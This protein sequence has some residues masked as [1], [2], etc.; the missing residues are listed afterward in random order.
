MK[1]IFSTLAYVLLLFST[2]GC[3]YEVVEGP[4]DSMGYVE[5]TAVMEAAPD[6]KTAMSELTQGMYYPLWSPE[7]EIAVFADD[8]KTP[9]KFVLSSGE[10]SVKA[11]F[12][13]NCTGEC[14][15]A[16]Y[17]Y[18]EGVALND[19][20]L[21][22][23]LPQTQKYVE[24]SFGQGAY[25]MIATGGSDGV[26]NFMNL[27][28][29]LKI[30]LSGTASVRA[31][32]V[33][34]NDK[35]TY[36]SGP[37][38]VSLNAIET[39][40]NFL[41]MSEGAS[42]SVTLD[43][44]GLEISNE[45]PADV[46][47]VIP[48]QTYKGGLTIEVDTF[49]ETISRVIEIDLTFA[50]SQL[51]SIPNFVL[52]SDMEESFPEV[53]T[54]QKAT[55]GNGIDIVLMGDAYTERQIKDGTYREEMEF[56]YENLFTEEPYA[57]FRDCFNVYYVNVISENEGYGNWE[58][59]LQGRFG[60]G[61]YVE[62]NHEAVVE[63]AEKAIPDGVLM[64]TLIVVAMNSDAYAGTCH[65]FY[66]NPYIVKDYGTGLSIAYF[67]RG[68]DPETFK[69]LLHHEACGHGFA[70]LDDEYDYPGVISYEE[71]SERLNNRNNWGWWK[72][73]DFTDD[74]S[75][76]VWA[77][78][79]ED[80]RYVNEKLGVFEGA[81]TYAEGAWRP[82]E[83]SIMRYNFGGFNAPSR[84]AI[85]YRIHK[86]AYGKN[87][88]YDYEEFVS[89]DA[90]NRT[91]AAVAAR[92]QQLNCVERTFEPTHPPVVGKFWRDVE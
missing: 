78:F 38:S 51:R 63:Y 7:D 5:L 86:L 26:L 9:S 14:Y 71:I 57:S 16:L 2:V 39:E 55:K 66:P 83:N 21:S 18:N 52:D 42:S 15:V 29:V 45:S 73:V 88:E 72:N 40:D 43:C 58:T 62:G 77:H 28:S 89:Y 19:G 82:T 4:V 8:D 68:G 11:E 75:E 47:I 37:A 85:Y 50:R 12:S 27:C 70:K 69:Q 41:A 64:E 23:T 1:K 10:G 61:T 25:P 84:E 56:I 32:T 53:V 74:P 22:L 36:L 54:L 90:V 76:V 17:P 91:K 79:L 34:A 59:A 44:Y 31:V 3:V 20:T 49:T 80:E 92:T 24:G 60:S 81:S 67:P 65:M 13:G 87:W 35:E 46:F 30:S 33:I 48:A 6:S